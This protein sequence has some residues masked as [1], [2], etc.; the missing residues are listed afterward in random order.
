MFNQCVLATSFFFQMTSY[1]LSLSIIDGEV[2]SENEENVLFKTGPK[3][4]NFFGETK[5]ATPPNSTAY[6]IP[7]QIQLRSFVF[8]FKY[9]CFIREEFILI[10]DFWAVDPLN[11]KKLST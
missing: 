3:R 5:I 1:G 7:S 11:K 8:F 6:R 10:D 4:K 2:A 9:K